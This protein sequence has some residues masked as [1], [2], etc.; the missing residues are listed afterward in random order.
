M[1]IFVALACL[2]FSSP[3]LADEFKLDASVIK[4][5]I[6]NQGASVTRSAAVDLPKG[7]H[8]LKLLIK[9]HEPNLH[10]LGTGKVSILATAINIAN[11]VE[12]RA[13]KSPKL[14]KLET[15]YEAARQEMRNFTVQA[16]AEEARR[17][18]AEMRLD[19]L[20]TLADGNGLSPKGGAHLN[21][22]DLVEFMQVL[23]AQTQAALA[24]DSDVRTKLATHVRRRIALVEK[25]NDAKAAMDRETAPDMSFREMELEVLVSEA[26]KG[27]LIA[28]GLSD[29]S[30]SWHPSYQFSLE[31]MGETGNLTIQRRA[32]VSS[33]QAENWSDVVLTLSTASLFSETQINEP[34]SQLRGLRDPKLAVSRSKSKRYANAQVSGAPEPMAELAQDGIAMFAGGGATLQGQTLLFDLGAGN[35]L[36]W[37]DTTKQF[38]L[39]SFTIP[40]DLYGMANAPVDKTAFLYTDF[41]NETGAILLQGRGQLYRDGALVGMVSL[42]MLTPGEETSLGLGPLLGIQVEHDTLSVMEGDS[43]F[44]T[45]STDVTR[46]FKTTLISSLDYAIPVKL[47]DVLP[48]SENEDLEISMQ[49]RPKPTETRRDGKRGVL[50]WDLDMTPG[51][52]KMVQFS[53]EMKWPKG[54]ELTYR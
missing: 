39:D 3:I 28:E 53:Y 31:Q 6:F 2:S 5:V 30:I 46:K 22:S 34:Q 40:V 45:S 26:F 23:D 52:T 1:R 13:A 16:E 24:V 32:I 12:V 8:Q 10:F 43:G 21:V 38:E 27:Q 48:T 50:E 29:A 14:I 35:D 41:T 19:F 20:S 47:L 42:P 9:E 15:A 17:K 36:A 11:P 44:I 37:N 33:S 54:Q 18:A 7:R 25:L 49:A 51:S 4:A